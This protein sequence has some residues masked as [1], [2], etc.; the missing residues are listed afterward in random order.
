MSKTWAWTERKKATK[1]S[2][3]ELDSR[4]SRPNSGR[5]IEE[6][7]CSELGGKDLKKKDE[8]V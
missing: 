1:S 7:L 6:D 8:N 3:R 2:K 5:C 4:S